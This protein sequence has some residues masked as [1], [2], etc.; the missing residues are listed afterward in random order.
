MLEIA[1]AETPK[2]RGSLER[3]LEIQGGD[4]SISVYKTSK[5]EG[6]DKQ[7]WQ[8]QPHHRQSVWGVC[9]KSKIS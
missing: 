5:N 7:L 8:T 4:F 1:R 2:Q 6:W 3:V 9:N